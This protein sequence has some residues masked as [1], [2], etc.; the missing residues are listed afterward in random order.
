MKPRQKT[1][2]ARIKAARHK[3][4]FSQNR[5]AK[6]WGFV[7]QTLNVWETRGIVPRGLYRRE[8]EEVLKRIESRRVVAQGDPVQCAGGITRRER[9][10]RGRD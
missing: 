6:E 8:L 1:Y 4:G 5:A 9:T 10:R 7:Q 3:L 2:S